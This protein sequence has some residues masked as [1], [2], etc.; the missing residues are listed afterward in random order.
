MASR[1]HDGDGH[2]CRCDQQGLI[3]LM[4]QVGVELLTRKFD[5]AQE[6]EADLTGMQLVYRAKSDPAGMIAFV[7]RLPAKGEWNGFRR[8]R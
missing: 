8:I 1:A 4:R 6:T 7:E 2:D 5:R 3:G